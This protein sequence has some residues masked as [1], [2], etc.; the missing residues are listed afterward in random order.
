MRRQGREQRQ[1]AGLRR[2]FGKGGFQPGVKLVRAAREAAVRH[3]RSLRAVQIQFGDKG[4]VSHKHGA[5]FGEVEDKGFPAG[6]GL[7]F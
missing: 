3:G 4:R 7:G 6:T 5:F 2:K 1:F